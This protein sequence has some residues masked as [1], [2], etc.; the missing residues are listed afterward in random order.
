M[1][2]LRNIDNNEDYRKTI[3]KG[4]SQIRA[5]LNPGASVKVAQ[6]AEKMIK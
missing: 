6:L 5:I 1:V 4:Y 2:E 3:E